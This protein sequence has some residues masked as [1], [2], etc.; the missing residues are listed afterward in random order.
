MRHRWHSGFWLESEIQGRDCRQTRVL[1]LSGLVPS[2]QE[3]GPRSCSPELALP[4]QV[5]VVAGVGGIQGDI[6]RRAAP[7]RQHERLA[8]AILAGSLARQL[9]LCPLR[10]PL[11]PWCRHGTRSSLTK[12]I[13]G[14]ASRS[15]VRPAVFRFCF[16]CVRFLHC[17]LLLG[18]VGLQD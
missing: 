6:L 18:R 4:Q 15:S 12:V 1:C 2:F 3:E 14:P 5:R 9:A 7:P 11:H 10:G 8:L 13:L 17:P 16:G